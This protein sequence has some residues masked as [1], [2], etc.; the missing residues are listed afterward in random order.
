MLVIQTEDRPGMLAN[1]TD[2]IAKLDSNIRQIDADT[3]VVG[4]GLINV[5]VEVKHRKQLE[6][7]RGA[8]QNIS[9]VL[10]VDRKVGTS[11]GAEG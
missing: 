3:E 11:V 8:I 10:Q 7:L 9:G 2:V 6:K 5:V 4:R 1:L